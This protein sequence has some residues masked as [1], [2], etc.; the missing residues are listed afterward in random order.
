MSKFAIYFDFKPDNEERLAF[1]QS[2]LNSYNLKEINVA[3]YNKARQVRNVKSAIKYLEYIIDENIRKVEENKRA[4]IEAQAK[5]NAQTS[6]LTEQ[7]KQ[8][9]LT[10]SWT[11]KKQEMLLEAKLKADADKKKAI[12]DELKAQENHKRAIELKMLENNNKR[13]IENEKETRKDDR[14][15]Q[16]STNTSKITD[17]RQNKSGA[18]DFTNKIE[19]IFKDNELLMEQ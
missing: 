19:D 6:V 3:Q 18:I 16:T 9:T 13:D 4:N 5:A 7:T 11:M 1:E 14:I 17:Q 10:V 2:L 15:D 8:Q 12:L